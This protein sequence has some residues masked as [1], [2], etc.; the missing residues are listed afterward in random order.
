M[1]MSMFFLVI[2][3]SFYLCREVL[4]LD[5]NIYELLEDKNKN[6]TFKNLPLGT[7]QNLLTVVNL[8]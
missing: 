5:L 7:L 3:S 6:K 8:H 4:S 1:I 2:V